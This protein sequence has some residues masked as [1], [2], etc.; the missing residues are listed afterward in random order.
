MRLHLASF[1]LGQVDLLEDVGHKLLKD[2]V[3]AFGLIDHEVDDLHDDGR[4]V[5]IYSYFELYSLGVVIP[6]LG[7]PADHCDQIELRLSLVLD[8]WDGLSEGDVG[9]FYLSLRVLPAQEL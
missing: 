8:H 4:I 9:R 7:V 2:R 6:V 1:L 3:L 5:L